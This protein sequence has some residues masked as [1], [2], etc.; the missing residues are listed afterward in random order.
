VPDPRVKTAKA[1]GLTVPPILLAMTD[2][3]IE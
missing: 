2:E 3:D 1:F